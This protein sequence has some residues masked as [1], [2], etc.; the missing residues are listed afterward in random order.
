MISRYH[1]AEPRKTDEDP[2]TEGESQLN[3]AVSR[4]N[5][6]TPI[7]SEEGRKDLWVVGMGEPKRPTSSFVFYFREQL[8]VPHKEKEVGKLAKIIGEQWK[9]LSL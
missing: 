3:H 5:D 7:K 6:D 1:P 4:N 9:A 2:E 8:R